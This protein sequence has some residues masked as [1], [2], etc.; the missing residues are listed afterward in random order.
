MNTEELKAEG[1]YA[2][3]IALSMGDEH[4]SIKETVQAY[5][6]NLQDTMSEKG[7]GNVADVALRAYDYYIESNI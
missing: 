7:L 2:A 4:G 5:R 6:E 1:K 3:L